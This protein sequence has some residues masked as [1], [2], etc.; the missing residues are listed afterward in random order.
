MEVIVKKSRL[1]AIV[2]VVVWIVVAALL[3]IYWNALPSYVSWPLAILEALVG[4][5]GRMFKLAFTS[6][7][8]S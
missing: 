2:M 8:A 7:P 5:D 1:V 3:I 6:P 4:S